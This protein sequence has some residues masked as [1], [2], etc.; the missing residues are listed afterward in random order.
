MIE[1]I[2]TKIYYAKYQHNNANNSKW[3]LSENIIKKLNMLKQRDMLYGS[4]H[5]G[6]AFLMS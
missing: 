6:L 2:I 1:K 4:T 5:E 3:I